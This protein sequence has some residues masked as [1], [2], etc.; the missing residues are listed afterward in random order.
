MTAPDRTRNAA[1]AP[2][3]AVIAAV[4]ANGVIGAGLAL[5]W[6]LPGDLARFRRLTT[7]HAIVMGRRTWQSLGRPLPG[8][9]NIVV[10][11]D[12]A[13]AADGARVVDSLD[14]ALAAVAMPPPVF[15]IGGAALFGEA[16]PRATT[17]HLTEV[18]ADVD[19]DVRFPAW[20]RAS[21]REMARDEVAAAP[22]AP[23]HA[24]VTLA[25]A[26]PPP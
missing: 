21:W 4:A 2:P 22:D 26:V 6:R 11:R 25:R 15:V 3:I 1:N 10:S 9:Q 20:D 24:F 17:F 13:F 18:H 7:G 14:A 16:L 23:A 8:R 5:P 19:G 12:P